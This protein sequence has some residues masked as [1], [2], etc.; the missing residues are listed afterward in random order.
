MVHYGL[1]NGLEVE[2]SSAAYAHAVKGVSFVFKTT[3]T[4]IKEIICQEQTNRGVLKCTNMLRSCLF[5][6]S[7]A[8]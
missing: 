4:T 6:N 2:I 3:F 5:Y 7:I 1:K 8:L